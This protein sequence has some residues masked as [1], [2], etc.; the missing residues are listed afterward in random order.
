[1]NYFIEKHDQ[2][3]FIGLELRTDNTAGPTTIPDH[4]QR[5][6][7]EDIYSQIPN[8]VDGSIFALYT[9]YEGDHT[10]PYSCIIGCEVANLDTIPAGLIGKVIP[11]SKYAVYTSQGAFPEGLVAAWQ[12]IWKS[13]LHRAYTADFEYYSPDFN[14]ATNPEIKVYIAIK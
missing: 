13:N 6:F 9:D 7:A 11:K 10:K 2:K 8:Q 1:M 4:W 3:F 5:F 12:A 14:P